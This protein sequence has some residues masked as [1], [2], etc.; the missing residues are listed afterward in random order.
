[1]A[2]KIWTAKSIA[3]RNSEP[4]VGWLDPSFRVQWMGDKRS[5]ATCEKEHTDEEV[6]FMMA[7]Y[8]LKKRL[9]RYPTY[10]EILECAAGLGYRLESPK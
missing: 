5:N 7:M 2:K 10:G 3:A 4:I 8:S 6:K 1:M 9:G